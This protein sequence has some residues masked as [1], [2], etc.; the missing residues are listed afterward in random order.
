MRRAGM[1]SYHANRS[2]VVSAIACAVIAGL[3]VGATRLSESNLPSES[4][5]RAALAASV[6]FA[7]TPGATA[8]APNVPIVVKAGKGQ[9]VAVR[10]TS[11]RPAAIGGTLNPSANEWRS[12]G[13]LA[14]GTEYDVTATVSGA[15]HL[16][17]QSTMKFRTLTPAPAVSSSVFPWEG[18]TVG[19]GQPIVFT[20]SRP[21]A[22][23]A[24]RAR[25]LG[26]LTVS[27]S[28]PIDGGWHWFSDHELHFRPRTFWLPG[29]HVTVAWDLT[30]WNASGGAW[31][32]NGGTTHFTV[33]DAHVSYANL[34]TD[35]MTVTDNGRTIATYPI[36]G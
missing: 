16:R 2:I 33:G 9:L 19:I 32:T 4:E 6:T 20:L 21:I 8:V 5:I 17:A 12:R 24:A 31:G 34:S 10:V 13:S 15:R 27:E 3:T 30:G 22:S 23:A 7:P 36:S 29:E 1:R 35:L 25:L 28:Q 26:H 18:L 14:Y 11:Q